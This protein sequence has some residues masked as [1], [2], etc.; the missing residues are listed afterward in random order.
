MFYIK[1]RII[2][3][4][5]YN[6]IS[7]PTIKK[8]SNNKIACYFQA[9][10][11]IPDTRH[12]ESMLYDFS[13]YLVDIITPPYAFAF[14]MKIYEAIKDKHTLVF[15]DYIKPYGYPFKPN[16]DKIAFYIVDA[17]ERKK[18]KYHTPITPEDNNPLG[19]MISN[20]QFSYWE[21]EDY[22]KSKYPTLN[23]DYEELQ[24]DTIKPLLYK[25]STSNRIFAPKSL[26][27]TIEEISFLDLTPLI[28]PS[29]NPELEG[30]SIYY[31]IVSTMADELS[32]D[33]DIDKS[34]AIRIILSS[35]NYLSLI[36]E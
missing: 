29:K 3:I 23:R 6:I 10:M 5:L 25:L 1:R 13:F 2:S 32:K 4:E 14:W 35:K 30:K 17:L 21:G 20:K 34:I 31:K 18:G 9:Y 28:N 15:L 16:K 19:K 27:Q 11:R 8:L 36:E 26:D 24:K 7:K 33:N 12:F 22:L